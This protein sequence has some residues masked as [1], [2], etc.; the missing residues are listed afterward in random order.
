MNVCH[1]TVICCQELQLK[2]QILRLSLLKGF[3][4]KVNVV[5]EFHLFPVVDNNDNVT[6]HQ[7]TYLYSE[8]SFIRKRNVYRMLL[9][10]GKRHNESMNSEFE[11]EYLKYFQSILFRRI[12][13]SGH[14]PALLFL[15]FFLLNNV[16]LIAKRITFNFILSISVCCIILTKWKMNCESLNYNK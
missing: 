2:L 4:A 13:L 10:S 7:G 15:H 11:H 16:H 3:M 14:M 8:K 5:H 12:T 6:L 1:L 9:S